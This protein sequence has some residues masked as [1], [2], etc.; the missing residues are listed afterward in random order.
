MDITLQNEFY[1]DNKNI[2]GISAK[3][4]ASPV[5][6]PPHIGEYCSFHFEREFGPLTRSMLP[7][8]ESFDDVR[9]WDVTVE[10]RR[11]SL[12]HELSW[13]AGRIDN[14]MLYLYLVDPQREEI[15][16]MSEQNRYPFKPENGIYN[17]IIYATQ[18]ASFSPKIVPLEFKLAQNYPNPFNPETTIRFGIPESADGRRVTLRVFNVLGQE[19][20][21]LVDRNLA[22]GYHEVTWNSTNHSGQLVSSGVYF[23]NL[24]TGKETIV[25]KMILVR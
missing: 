8:F 20:A 17:F 18:D 25:R 22:M 9:T 24:S 16:N 21:T 12:E 2:F 19:I 1:I 14:N 7:P 13:P 6:E 4:N 15:I 11:I 3:R 5:Y 23:Y 10:S